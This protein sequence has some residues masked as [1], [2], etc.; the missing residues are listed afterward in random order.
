LDGSA[1]LARYNPS[2]AAAIEWLDRH[3]D[4][5]DV[6]VEA[7]GCGYGT[8]GGVPMNRVSA[9]SGVPAVLGWRNHEGQWRRGV[10][11]IGPVLD[12]RQAAANAWLDG[13]AL[14]A[15][16]PPR[17]RF[18][19]IGAQE[20]EGSTTCELVSD[21]SIDVHSALEEAGWQV[22]FDSGGTRVYVQPGDPSLTGVGAA[23]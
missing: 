5:G 1:Y 6:L 7:P 13:Q 2:D 16:D 22:A 4:D 23:D 21:R 17:P 19:V 18:I 8:F 14:D 10:E 9:F 20:L 12:D 11:G 15:G 3:A